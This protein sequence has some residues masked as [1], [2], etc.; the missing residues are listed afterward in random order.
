MLSTLASEDWGNGQTRISRTTN[1]S[2][3]SGQKQS[4]K[5]IK[6]SELKIPTQKDFLKVEEAG[7]CSMRKSRA[8][9]EG[10]SNT[11]YYD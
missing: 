8:D 3:Q 11:N 1:D 10:V 9:E 5:L 2:H 7:D 4:R 6:T